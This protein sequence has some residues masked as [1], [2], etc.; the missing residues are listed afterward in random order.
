MSPA[1]ELVDGNFHVM[2]ARTVD[3]C[4]NDTQLLLQVFV[5]KSD[6]RSKRMARKAGALVIFVV[7]AS[8]SMALNRMSAAKGAIMRLL[9]ES[10]TARDQVCL[11]PFYGDKADVLLPP[12]KSISLARKRLDSLPCGGGSPL[13]HGLS[14]AVRNGINAQVL[15]QLLRCDVMSRAMRDTSQVWHDSLKLIEQH[16]MSEAGMLNMHCAVQKSGDTGRVMVVCI[17][18]GRANVGLAKSNEDP[19]AL[20][21]GAPKPSKDELNQEVIDMA[22]HCRAAGFSLLVIDTEN[23]FVSTGF[24]EEI[25]RAGSGK[26]YYL[27]NANESA[28]AAATSSAMAAAKAE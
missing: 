11:I 28:I 12:S 2:Q 19:E 20:A 25:A 13:A 16:T 15:P 9:G 8:G 24:A 7:D 17:T 26:Y 4:P 21:E 1:F 3:Q 22:T 27:P 18:D 10:Y 14:L 23:K 6:M 5:E